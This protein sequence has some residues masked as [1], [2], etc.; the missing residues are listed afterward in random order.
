MNMKSIPLLI[1]LPLALVLTSVS[2]TPAS[3]KHHAIFQLSEPEGPEWSTVVVRVNNMRTA[4]EKDGGVQIEVVFFGAG[5]N[6]LRKTNSAY[7]QRLKQLSDN[8]VIL[9][10]CQ[11][12]MRLF[13][14]KTED[15]FPF[16][17]QV[18]AGVAELT[19]KQEAGWAYI[20]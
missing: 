11:N 3:P 10:A 4:F 17:A 9:S 1:V 20:H 18:D 19:R 8:G 13:N 14:V 16:A 6:M 7:E 15:L 5:V 12:A 2:Q